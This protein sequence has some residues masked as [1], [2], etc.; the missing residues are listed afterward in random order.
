[1][2]DTNKMF[3]K[4][5]WPGLSWAI[6]IFIL[7]TIS[8]PAIYLPNFFDLF[9]PDKVAHFIIYAILVFLLTVGFNKSQGRLSRNQFSFSVLFSASYGGL[10]EIYQGYCLVDRIGDWV[11]FLANCIG[12]LVGYVISRWMLSRK[13]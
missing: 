1:M 13:K 12:C 5:N 2:L 7:S 6:V 3:I 10:I 8:P 11:D 4:N 9:T